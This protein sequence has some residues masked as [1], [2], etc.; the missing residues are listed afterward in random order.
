MVM[1][2][3]CSPG[4]RTGGRDGGRVID[5]SA[6]A[7]ASSRARRISACRSGVIA[8][9]QAWP[10]PRGR[11]PAR[12]DRIFTILRGSYGVRG[13]DNRG[14]VGSGD[15]GSI[16]SVDEFR[17]ERAVLAKQRFDQAWSDRRENW[18]ALEL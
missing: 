4:V 10:P 15:V 11:S 14:D 18:R 5:Q 2:S 9:A 16:S 13:L 1:V 6:R 12:R 3:G 17:E 8:P 7:L